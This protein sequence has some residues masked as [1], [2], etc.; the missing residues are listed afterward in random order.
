MRLL[1]RK[2]AQFGYKKGYTG[3]RE[4]G[5]SAQRSPLGFRAFANTDNYLR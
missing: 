5:P 4:S 1:Y 2:P 3:G